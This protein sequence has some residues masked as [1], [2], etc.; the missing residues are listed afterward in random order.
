MH[1]VRRAPWFAALAFL[2]ALLTGATGTL[3]EVAEASVL[4]SLPSTSGASEADLAR[5]ATLLESRVMVQRLADYGLTVEEAKAK[6]AAMSD[7]D[8]SRLAAAADRAPEGG[9]LLG[10]LILVAFLVLLVVVILKV[11]DKEIILR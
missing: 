5:I 7:A 6:V 3:S 2:L 1:P 10:D 11:A 9:S 8:L 4:P